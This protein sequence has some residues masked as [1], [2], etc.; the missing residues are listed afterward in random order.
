MISFKNIT[1]IYFLILII[2]LASCSSSKKEI[3][4]M[5]NAR[6]GQP[7]IIENLNEIRVQ[8]Q[9]KVSIVVSCKEPELAS[10]FNLV[11]AQRTIGSKGGSGSSGA[12]GIS[13]Y[14]VD[15]YGDINF[16]VLGRIKIAG[17]TRQ[18]IS[19]KIA[20]MLIKGD[21]VS[22][23]VVT[24]EFANLHFTALGE[25]GSPGAHSIDNDRI[26]LLEAS[27]SFVQAFS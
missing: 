15:N 14:T 25:V 26:T 17:L 2:G 16:P 13:A 9:D 20:D 6:Y 27:V 3:L 18:E 11:S 10:L 22:D 7:E 5:Q 23:P 8:P 24:V 12:S 21:W 4:Y 19:D 1:K